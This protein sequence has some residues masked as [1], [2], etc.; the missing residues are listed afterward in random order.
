MMRWTIYFVSAGFVCLVGSYL[1]LFF[2][3][4]LTQA[5][6]NALLLMF[7]TIVVWAMRAYQSLIR[8]IYSSAPDERRKGE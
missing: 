5:L 2:R 3:T 7:I 6:G 1:Y 8:K 4:G